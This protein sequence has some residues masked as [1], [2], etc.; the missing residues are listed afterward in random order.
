MKQVT[1]YEVD[2][3]RGTYWEF[4]DPDEGFIYF[5]GP[6]AEMGANVMDLA[7]RGHEV[8]VKSQEAYRNWLVEKHEPS[9]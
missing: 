5:D 6:D 9:D 3:D 4:D 2:S 8:I 7:R 1:V